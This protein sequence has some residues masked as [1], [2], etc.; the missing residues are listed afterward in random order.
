MLLTINI[1]SYNHARFIL[2]ALQAAAM[3]EIQEKEII[4][5][6]DGSSDAS[7]NVVRE[8]IAGKGA[9]HNIKLIARENRGLVKTLNEGLAIAQGKYFYNV[10]SDDIPIP[11]GISSLINHLETNG[12][13][14]FAMGNALFMDS[15]HQR[16]FQP[17]YGESHLRFFA[18][19]YDK[20][21]KEMYLRLPLPI[22]LQATVFKTSVLREVGG[23]RE[24]IVSDDLYMW[25]R[26]FTQMRGVG[27]DFAY[28]PDVIACFYRRHESNI[29]KNMERQFITIDEVLTHLCPPKWRDAAYVRNFA[30]YAITAVKKG[31]IRLAVRMYRATIAHMSLLRWLRV[32]S[33][34]FI[35]YLWSRLSS[36]FSRNILVAHES[37]ATRINR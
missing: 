8:Y 17:A 24:D 5:I 31:N 27:K 30:A 23:W 2:K 20:R 4:V 34:A 36:R 13:L 3:I 26:L 35:N 33:P 14:Q 6:D 25:L 37:A 7:V 28:Q 32:V 29:S 11:K 22:L 12:D 21:Q 10:A 9:G 1:P 15:E 19:S 16:R 18:L